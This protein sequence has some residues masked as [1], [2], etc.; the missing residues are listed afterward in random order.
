MNRHSCAGVI[1]WGG[2]VV[3]YADVEILK[4]VKLG[5]CSVLDVDSRDFDRATLVNHDIL[6]IVGS[7]RMKQFLECGVYKVICRRCAAKP[8]LTTSD[9]SVLPYGLLLGTHRVGKE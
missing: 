3:A 9:V 2:R 5:V 8:R 7:V 1:R 4:F 6:V